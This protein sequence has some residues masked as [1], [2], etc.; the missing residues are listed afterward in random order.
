MS[1]KTKKRKKQSP[2][3]RTLTALG[4]SALTGWRGAAGKA[5]AR[6]VASRTRFSQEQIEA[7]IGLLIL[8][9]GLY[10][11]LRPPIRAVR[12]AT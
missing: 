2:T 6:P 1:P 11:V 4:E 3:E 7:A 5:V 8:A 10:R 9:Y 12:T